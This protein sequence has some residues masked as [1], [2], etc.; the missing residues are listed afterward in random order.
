MTDFIQTDILLNLLYQDK[1]LKD[2]KYHEFK[3]TAILPLRRVN[4]ITSCALLKSE[5]KIS[6][7]IA[8]KQSNVQRPKA[9]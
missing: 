1:I 5:F 4:T 3:I 6:M 7:Q 8:L 9:V 2:K